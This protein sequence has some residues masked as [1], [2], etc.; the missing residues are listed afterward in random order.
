MRDVG[1]L[2]V[3]WVKPRYQLITFIYSLNYLTLLWQLESQKISFKMIF[4]ETEIIPTYFQKNGD[5]IHPLLP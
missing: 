3:K 5:S 1:I 4:F 2:A